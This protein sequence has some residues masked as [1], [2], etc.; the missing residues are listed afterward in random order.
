MNR[1]HLKIASLLAML[2]LLGGC[3]TVLDA[4]KATATSEGYRYSLPVPVLQVTPQSDGTMALEVLYLPDPNNT[5]AVQAKSLLGAHTLDVKTKNGLLDTVSFNT[6]ATGVAEAGLNAYGDIRKAQIEK[7]AKDDEDAAKKLDDKAKATAASAKALTDAERA[8]ATAVAKRDRLVELGVTGDLLTAAE[9]AV[10]DAQQALLAL[11]ADVAAKAGSSAMNQAFN[12]VGKFPQAAGPIFF[13]MVPAVPVKD[14]KTGLWDAELG[15]VDLVADQPQV[16]GPTA[17][18]TA[19]T[20]GAPDLAYSIVGP[21][22]VRPSKADGLTFKIRVN[23]SVYEVVAPQLTAVT[24]GVVVRPVKVVPNKEGSDTY[25][26]V[27][28]D[29]NQASGDYTLDI[30]VRTKKGGVTASTDP[31]AFEVRRKPK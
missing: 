29:D 6:D 26:V 22:V 3:V 25:L 16:K 13:R 4:K 1:Q 15:R 24:H 17:K 23:Q 2:P 31:V 11:Q 30:P 21:G 18:P 27:T 20:P 12:Q 5:Y 9:L 10:V 28:L 7:Q 14:P 8:V 19:P